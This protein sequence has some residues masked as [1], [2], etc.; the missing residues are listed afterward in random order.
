MS[1]IIQAFFDYVCPYCYLG[2]VILA[3]AAV[4]T[5][6][7]II[8]RAY[9]LHDSS[10]SKFDPRG[11][12][13][14]AAWE[15]SVYPLAKRLG[16]EMRQPS[17]LPL[18]RQAHEAAAWARRYGR[19]EQFHTNLFRSFF[20][21]DKDLSELRVLKEV[22]WQSGLN[23]NELEKVLTEHQ[24]AEEVDEDLLI[25]RTYGINS[26]PTFVIAGHLLRG[27]QEEA[28]L[29]NAIELASTGK[30]QAETRKLPHPPISITKL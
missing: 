13:L 21:E 16:V 26:V 30:F 25:G 6:V 22:A 1:M 15:N 19:F 20:L 4:P 29:T 14:N 3:K 12:Q 27:V 28:I 10:P 11:D 23:A 18:T 9:Q 17:R 2:E 7:E 24:M 5:G 8:R